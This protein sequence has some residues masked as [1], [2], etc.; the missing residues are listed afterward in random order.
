MITSAVHTE[1]STPTLV[2]E[3]KNYKIPS[4]TADTYVRMRNGETL[5]IG[6]LI[7]EEEQKNI[8]KIPSSPIFLF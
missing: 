6:G 2:S 3:I 4:R 7:N 5:I 8:Q 1:V